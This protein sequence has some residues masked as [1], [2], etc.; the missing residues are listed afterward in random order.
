MAPSAQPV[1]LYDGVCGLC[2]RL[3]QFTLRHDHNDTFH[4]AALQGPVAARILERHG[5]SPGDLDTFYVVTGMD[6]PA[7]HLLARSDAALY[8]L[9]ELGGGWSVVA[10]FGR[11]LPKALRDALYNAIARNRYRMFGKFDACP[12]PDPKVRHKFLQ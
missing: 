12:L 9:R 10:M 6:Q 11:V 2:N 8:V 4:F 5:Q 7:E 1:L 3:V